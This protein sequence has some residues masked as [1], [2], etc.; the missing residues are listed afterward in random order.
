MGLVPLLKKNF[1]AALGYRH[2][3]KNL[4]EG[5]SQGWKSDTSDY[6]PVPAYAQGISFGKG[7][8]GKY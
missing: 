1:M 3:E 6:H 2:I 5:A 4:V 8:E 7:K